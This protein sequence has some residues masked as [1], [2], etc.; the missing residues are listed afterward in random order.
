[1]KEEIIR[2][3]HLKKSFPV[4]GNLFEKKQ[5]VRAVNN[6]SFSIAEGET[7]GI[8]GESG[9]GKSTLGRTILKIYE[10]DEGHIYYRGTDITKLNMKQ[11][12][13]Y[14]RKM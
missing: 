14:R 4:K 8:V 5:Y 6:I 7:L 3:E 13:P 2:I 11:M 10:P 12:H 1:M 9:C